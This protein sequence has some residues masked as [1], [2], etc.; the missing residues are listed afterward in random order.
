MAL[1]C[2][3]GGAGLY[4]GYRSLF[5]LIA[6]RWEMGLIGVMIGV[7]FGAGTF[8]LCRHRDDLLSF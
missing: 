3:A 4:L 2:I 6:G 1:I 5:D 8:A 7:A